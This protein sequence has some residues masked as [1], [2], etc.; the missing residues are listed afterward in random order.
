MEAIM[1]LPHIIL[2]A[3]LILGIPGTILRI[4]QE[5]R[6]GTL[7]GTLLAMTIGAIIIYAIWG[8]A[9]YNV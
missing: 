6:K 5:A 8:W 3:W 1:D 9:I 2:W 4:A 7:D